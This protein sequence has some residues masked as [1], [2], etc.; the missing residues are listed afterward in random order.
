MTAVELYRE[1]RRKTDMRAKELEMLHGSHLTC[2]RGCSQ[3]CVNLTV[4]P[5]EFHAILE[6][7]RHLVPAVEMQLYSKATCALLAQGL[8]T[9]YASR[10]M[11]CRTH[12]LPVAFLNMEGEE[13][14]MSVS[15]CPL[16]FIDADE[17][18]LS[19]GESNVIDIDELNMELYRANLQFLQ[20]H[21]ELGFEPSDRIDLRELAVQLR[22]AQEAETTRKTKAD[23]T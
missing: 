7:L 19:F 22:Q 4:F 13:P 20:E 5:V 2:R 23:T 21:P 14:E 10:P 17:D 1:L 16:N 12:G 11:I 6:E 8:C 9:I 3:C 15:F 18:L